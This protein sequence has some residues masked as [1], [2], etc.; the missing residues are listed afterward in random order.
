M[1]LFYLVLLL[2]TTAVYAD[3][4]YYCANTSQS[5]SVGETLQQVFACCGAP[6]NTNS[7]AVLA[8]TPNASS[9]QWV[10]TKGIATITAQGIVPA[11]NSP[12]VIFTIENGVVTQVQHSG[13][14]M[15]DNIACNLVQ[16]LGVTRTAA[17]ARVTCGN[18]TYIQAIPQI[19]TTTHD[20]TT[21]TYNHGP[22][23]PQI[24]FTFTDGYLSNIK[25]GQLGT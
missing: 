3:N 19:N 21:W 24:I 2:F 1:R 7:T 8:Q 11:P 4:S 13:T 22:Y 12:T 23:Q 5:V 18:P 17:A 16:S 6:T 14:A 9:Q 10:Y 15:L 25:A 20:I